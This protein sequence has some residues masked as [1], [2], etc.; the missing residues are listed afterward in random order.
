MIVDQNTTGEPSGVT[1]MGLQRFCIKVYAQPPAKVDDAQFI[2]I[3][4]TWIQ[5]QALRGILI[6]VA[7][8]RH[9]ARGPGVML[10]GYEANLSMERTDG[11]LGLV[12]Q[13]KVEQQDPLP[14][15]LLN[16]VE[17][18]LD[19]C[20]LLE[21]DLRLDGQLG[22]SGNELVFIANDR[23][24]VPNNDKAQDVLQEAL[25]LVAHE[26]YGG[27]EVSVEPDSQDP[28]ERPQVRIRTP[29]PHDITTLLEALRRRAH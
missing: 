13:R 26:L 5:R 6:D 22:F 18:T 15:R 24:R 2:D 16:A 20:E 14:V 10:I 8:Y 19:A 3:F 9:I 4:H 11:R 27:Q 1:E 28:R 25:A 21:N 7:D 29:V 23:L 17:I 12:Y